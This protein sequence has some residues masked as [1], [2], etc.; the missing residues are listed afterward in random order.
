MTAMMFDAAKAGVSR[1]WFVDAV[2]AEGIPVYKGYVKPLYH[3]TLY[4]KRNHHVLKMR[5]DIDYSIGL[6]PNAEDLHFSRLFSMMILRPKMSE[7]LFS[8]IKE[9]FGKVIDRVHRPDPDLTL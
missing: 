7:E 5:S 2:M 3:Q 4:Q 1:D 8:Q 6:C 9:A